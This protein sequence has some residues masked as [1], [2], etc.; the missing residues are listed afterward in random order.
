MD[1]TFTSAAT[2]SLEALAEL[3]TRSFE[4]YFYSGTTTAESLAQRVRTEHIDLWASPVLLADGEPSG[5]TLIARR[6]ARAWCGGFGIVAACRGLGLAHALTDEL[7]RRARDAGAQWL[8]LEVLTRNDRAIRAYQRAG[9]A[10]TRRLLVFSW[11]PGDDDEDDEELP[12]LVDAT[13][14]SLL[15]HFAELHPVLP[16]WQRDLPAL[17]VGSGRRGIY[18]PGTSSPLAYALISGDTENTRIADLGAQNAQ[19]AYMLLRGLQQHSHSL[20]SVNE[21]AISP[22]TAAFYRAGFV[23]ADEQHE[24]E[25]ML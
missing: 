15:C 14:E 19:S 8:T 7:I 10:I 9:L 12:H 24:M 6:G 17:L 11:R 21:P 13:P 1:I 3:F 5:V 25:I 20:I 18:L 2:L 22:L 4:G 16:A 23:V